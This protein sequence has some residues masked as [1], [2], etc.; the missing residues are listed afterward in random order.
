LNRN[1]LEK[2]IERILF[3][4]MSFGLHS[5]V[6][7]IHD[8]PITSGEPDVNFKPNMA[9]TMQ[10]SVPLRPSELMAIQLADER[11]PIEDLEY[12]PVSVPALKAAVSALADLVPPDQVTR[13]YRRAQELLD[14][15]TERQAEGEIAKSAEVEE[16]LKLSKDNEE[17]ENAMSK[18][19]KN[20]SIASRQNRLS[21]LI[22][23]LSEASNP[24]DAAVAGAGGDEFEA[25]IV[26]SGLQD[27]VNPDEKSLEEIADDLGYRSGASGA[28]QYIQNLLSKI[29]WLLE[30]VGIDTLD[31]LVENAYNEYVEAL[32]A[33]VREM[34]DA[35]FL[36]AEDLEYMTSP[37]NKNFILTSGG[38]RY[39]LS[40][41]FLGPAWSETKKA[42]NSIVREQLER[43]SVPT[44]LHQMVMNIIEGS[45]KG[46][47]EKLKLRR[48]S[49]YVETQSAGKSPSEIVDM[50]TSLMEQVREFIT[51]V[52]QE[53]NDDFFMNSIIKYRDLNDAKKNEILAQSFAVMASEEKSP[54]A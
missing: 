53:L 21:K 13:F 30:T 19:T 34:G 51:A 6:S 14:D 2:A 54:T 48:I 39:F 9:S 38:F 26:K 35:A 10:S 1:K 22:R 8:R 7:T 45:I 15:V 4:D 36:D 5:K 46:D 3:E 18:N 29:R 28:A 50:K 11:P 12:S 20:E 32:E 16:E 37:Q 25:E 49:D 31:S 23:I 27:A 47:I 41:A 44:K 42:A 33:D 17:E 52:K 40:H 43:S 24:Y